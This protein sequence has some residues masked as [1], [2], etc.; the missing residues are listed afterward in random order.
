MKGFIDYSLFFPIFGRGFGLVFR[1]YAAEIGFGMEKK[2]TKWM[3]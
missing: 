3:S 2:F 1:V